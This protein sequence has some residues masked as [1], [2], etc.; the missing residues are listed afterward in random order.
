MGAKNHGI[1]PTNA[2]MIQGGANMILKAS[3]I[4]ARE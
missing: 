3:N 4:F 2:D 1:P